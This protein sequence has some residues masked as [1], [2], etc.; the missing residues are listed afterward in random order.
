[1][2]TVNINTAA[3]LAAVRRAELEALEE[4]GAFV[5]AN[6]KQ[7][8]PVRKVYKER[9]GFRRAFRPLTGEERTQ[10]IARQQAF[11]GHTVPTRMEAE[12]RRPG[13]A[14][15][16]V[17]SRSIRR[18]G[19]LQGGKFSPLQ[20]VTASR[21]RGG[22]FRIG[23]SPQYGGMLTS[24]GR[25]EVSSGRAINEVATATGSRLEVG[26]KLKA[27]IESE[28]AITQGHGVTVKVSARIRYAK[29]VEFPTRHNAAQPFLLPALKDVKA[30][31][32]SML[33]SSLR[34]HLGG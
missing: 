32:P 30:K 11:Y 3:I 20:A 17:R 21:T 29:Y 23:L 25:Y 28:G 26:G 33:Q 18:L 14:N 15:A 27:S 10:V 1:V 19:T 13:S 8:A 4:A 5:A 7:R 6:A 16:L 31:L 12:I 2:A 34:R 24:R 22:G 9:K